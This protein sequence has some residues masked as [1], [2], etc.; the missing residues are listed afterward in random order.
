MVLLENEE[1]AVLGMDK[2]S[3]DA[4]KNLVLGKADSSSSR[5]LLCSLLNESLDINVCELTDI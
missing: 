1:A 2:S 5:T 3:E 4:D